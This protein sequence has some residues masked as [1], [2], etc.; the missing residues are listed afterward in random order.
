MS[1][2]LYWSV[3]TLAALEPQSASITVPRGIELAQ[4]LIEHA[5]PSYR[6]QLLLIAWHESRWNPHAIGDQGRAWGAFQLH[7]PWR[8]GVPIYELTLSKQVVLALDAIHY[9]RTLCGD[10]PM[11]WL[12]AFASGKCGGAPAKARELC[13]PLSL[14]NGEGEHDGDQKEGEGEVNAG[15]GKDAA[16]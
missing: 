13:A 9:L 2:S 7:G 16:S 15:K 12:G 3:M 8:V 6:A 11:R 5:P 4:A 1:V 14:C 10:H